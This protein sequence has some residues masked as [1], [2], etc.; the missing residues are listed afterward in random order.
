MQTGGG[1]SSGAGRRLGEL[2]A[3]ER[4]IIDSY[5]RNVLASSLRDSGVNLWNSLSPR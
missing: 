4:D 5:K 2:P 1:I 3:D